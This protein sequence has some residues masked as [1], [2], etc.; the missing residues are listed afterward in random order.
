MGHQYH[1]QRAYSQKRPPMTVACNRPIA[2]K[3]LLWLSLLLLIGAV[4]LFTERPAWGLGIDFSSS[5]YCAGGSSASMTIGRA[6][7]SQIGSVWTGGTIGSSGPGG[8]A[9]CF[10]SASIHEFSGLSLLFGICLI[11]T[12]YGLR[13][14]IRSTKSKKDMQ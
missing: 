11:T 6:V 5:N 3:P 10:I 1:Y 7:E 9:G 4:I 8:N 2:L 12:L 14:L 13:L